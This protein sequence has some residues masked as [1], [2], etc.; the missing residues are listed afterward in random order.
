MDVEAGIELWE[1]ISVPQDLNLTPFVYY[2]VYLTVIVPL[3]RNKPEG[4]TL[5]DILQA[6][7][8]VHGGSLEEWMLRRQMLP[9][10]Q[11]AGLVEEGKD[12]DDKRRTLYTLTKPAITSTPPSEN[13]PEPT[14]N[15]EPDGVPE[16]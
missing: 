14:P 4:V 16:E 6:Y 1:A 13:D 10:L 2:Q 8:N 9:S 15:D 3:C 11:N 12:P 5:T 7:A